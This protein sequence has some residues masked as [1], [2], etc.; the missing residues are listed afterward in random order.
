MTFRAL[1]VVASMLSL[2]TLSACAPSSGTAEAEFKNQIGLGGYAIEYQGEKGEALNFESFSKLKAEGKLYMTRSDDSNKTAVLQLISESK[3]DPADAQALFNKS[4]SGFSKPSIEVGATMPDVRGKTLEGQPTQWL[5]ASGKYSLLS[6][7]FAECA[8]CI[9]EVPE[10]NAFAKAH[11]DVNLIGVT[12]DSADDARKFRNT[13]DLEIATIA[14]AQ[15]SIDAIGIK[16]YPTLILVGPGGKLVASR[17]G[18][19]VLAPSDNG[20]SSV[21]TWY[22]SQIKSG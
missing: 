7:Y 19:V 5:A 16:A 10:L 1:F 9:A 2:L 11:P 22:L 6:F 8:P 14:E 18:G 12:F 13:H 4:L 3:V 20:K 21:E 15:S 17:A